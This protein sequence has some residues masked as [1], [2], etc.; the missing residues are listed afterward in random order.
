M[1]EVI[2]PKDKH[3]FDS[4]DDVD[5]CWCPSPHPRCPKN[6]VLT[7]KGGLADVL[8]DGNDCNLGL[9]FDP[10]TGKLLHLGED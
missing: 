3:V 2:C 6:C 1:S 10:V 5:L 7:H 9:A 8:V 4:I